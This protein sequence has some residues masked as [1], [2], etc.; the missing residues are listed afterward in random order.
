MMLNKPWDTN[1]IFI[2]FSVVLTIIS[3]SINQNE[4]VQVKSN[5]LLVIDDI[6]IIGDRDLISDELNLDIGISI[7]GIYDELNKEKISIKTFQTL[8]D[9]AKNDENI[10]GI[11][12][13]IDQ[14]SIPFNKL[15]QVRTILSSFKEIKPIFS[16]SDFH[17]KSAYYLS[18]ISDFLSVSPPGFISI[19][20]FGIFD[21]FYKELFDELGVKI[22]LFRVGE[23]K[24]A[25]ETYVRNDFSEENKQQGLNI[26]LSNI[27]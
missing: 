26:E 13:N 15:K 5:S 25:A 3:T 2:I 14:A 20:G 18:S 9:S 1:I 4:V 24:G 16:Y 17:T 7:P 11:Y 22:E 6:N 10:K 8:I 12:L 21:F 23:F 19:S 27:N